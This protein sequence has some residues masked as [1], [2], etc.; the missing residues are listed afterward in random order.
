MA[1]GGHASGG[2]GT[3]GTS[4]GGKA[5]QSVD[6]DAQPSSG[7]AGGAG[8]LMNDAAAVV[9]D[10]SVPDAS[11]GDGGARSTG[12]AKCSPQP[13]L[14]ID[15]PEGVDNV[16][17][18]HNV[19]RLDCKDGG[20]SRLAIQ[21]LTE[22]ACHCS[23]PGGNYTTC[24]EVPPDKFCLDGDRFGCP[25]A[26]DGVRRHFA[27]LCETAPVEGDYRECDDGTTRVN[28]RTRESSYVL[29]F[30]DSGQLG[31][32]RLNGNPP[33][34]G[35]SYC[36]EDLEFY[37]KG[38]TIGVSTV[39]CSV[40]SFTPGSEDCVVDSAGRLSLPEHP[41]REPFTWQGY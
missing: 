29:G 38:A 16:H 41:R 19:Y 5:V 21:D 20:A 2:T 39:D 10:A 4:T 13:R 36:G 34:I 11:E 12:L 31:L 30:D 6:G 3:G 1:T 33:F 23:F 8:G 14:C 25:I 27:A 35:P 26:L 24:P 28:W 18:V 17:R 7:G 9:A 15:E 22:F 37:M 32:G 40:C